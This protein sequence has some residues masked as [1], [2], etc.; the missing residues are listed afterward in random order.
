LPGNLPATAENRRLIWRNCR[1]FSAGRVPIPGTGEQRNSQRIAGEKNRGQ[2][3]NCSGRPDGKIDLLRHA[4]A[5]IAEL[6]PEA[7][8]VALLGAGLG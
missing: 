5:V 6:V 2:Q 3:G 4:E 8:T 7:G 1:A